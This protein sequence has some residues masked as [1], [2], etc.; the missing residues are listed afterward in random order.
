MKYPTSTPATDNCVMRLRPYLHNGVWVFDDPAAGLC[1]EMFVGETNTLIDRLV[2]DSGLDL[3]A[4]KRD[5]FHLTFGAVAFPGATHRFDWV[6]EDP[7]SGNWYCFA[8]AMASGRWKPLDRVEGWLCPSLF[9]Y[10]AKAPPA[11]YARADPV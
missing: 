8:A 6:R 2:T 1:K 11:I 10:F 7:E 3:A 5:G 9:K 4:S